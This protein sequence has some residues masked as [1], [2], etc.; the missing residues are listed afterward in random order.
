MAV[1]S[2]VYGSSFTTVSA[3]FRIVSVDADNAVQHGQDNVLIS[4]VA[5]GAVHGLV[6]WG[7]VQQPVKSWTDTAI[8]VGP[9]DTT[10]LTVGQPYAW[11]VWRPL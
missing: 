1:W 3:G 7:G 4:V 5:A 2:D 10:G 6:K 9:V 11:D 8:I